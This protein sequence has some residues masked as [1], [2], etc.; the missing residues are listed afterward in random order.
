MQVQTNLNTLTNL[1]TEF[2]AW[3]HFDEEMIEAA[4]RV[5]RSGKVNYW[6]GNE[7]REFEREYAEFVGCQH[8]IALANGTVALELAL[9]AL[10]IGAGDEVIVP[11][12]TFIATASSVVARGARPV[13]ADVDRESQTLTA[14]TIAPLITPRTKA[15]IPVHL[16]GWPCDMVPIL[17]LAK[18]RGLAVI[19]DCAQAHG[20]EYRGRPVGSWGDM[21]AFSF[22]QDKIIT[23]AGEGGLLVTNNTELWDK[24]WRY[25][26]HGKSPQAFY[27]PAPPS[28]QFRWLHEEFGSNYRL[29][30]VQAAIGRIMLRRLPTWREIRR[31]HAKRL[32]DA[33]RQCPGLRTPSP[34]PDV[35]HG[36]YKFYTFVRPEKLAAGWSRDR[37]IQ[38]IRN[39]GVP[40]FSG[41]CSEIYLEEAFPLAWRPRPPHPVAAELGQT[42][43]MFLVHPTLAEGRI[44]E[45]C[46]VMTDVLRTA[47]KA[48]T[49]TL[50]S[51]A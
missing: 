4:T 12:R 39:Q 49:S 25:K 42:S 51:A 10:G 47:T 22:C 30:E 9:H 31:A 19:E 24:A 20:A 29:S 1:P 50:V 28:H 43:L 34:G 32:G 13:C 23:T 16:A 48:D 18:S 15:I 17:E 8:A 41:S 11:S 40:C 46:H 44:H 37:M 7:G 45:T 35:L 27:Q 21:A 2:G 6:T 38:A 14:A 36:Y 26:D 5:L 33:C 3:P